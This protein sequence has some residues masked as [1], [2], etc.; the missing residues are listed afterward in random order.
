MEELRA[1][2][3]SL[4]S[5]RSARPLSVARLAGLAGLLWGVSHQLVLQP[6]DAR[7]A[8][9][10]LMVSVAI[11]WVGWM[12][13]RGL[14]APGVV[15]WGFL[16]LLAAAGGALAGYAPFA[17][18]FVAIAS[19]GAGIAFDTVG[20]LAIGAI[21]VGMVVMSVLVLGTSS[22]GEIVAEAALCAVAG[23]M[24]GNSRRQ[25]TARTEQ[26]ELLLAERM[27]ADA[28]RDTAAA[29]AERNRLGREVHDVLAHSLGALS[30]QL[31]AADAVLEQGQDPEKARQLVR[32]ARQL[33]VRGLEE[34]RQ[35]VHALRDDPVELAEQLVSLADREGAS[36]TVTG[37]PHRMA[38]DAGL[39]LYRVAQ[40]ALTNARKHAP[41]AAVSISL[42]FGANTTVLAV[43]NGPS[44]GEAN[45]A[46]LR[47]SGGG[48]GLR[49]MQERIELVGG[50]VCA[51]PTDSGFAVR[52][53][54]PG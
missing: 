35:A 10:L 26:A 17:L 1:R 6:G 46:D 29:L 7:W 16:A 14:S 25:Y 52:A 15:V 8:V 40:E 50:E 48:F 34:T 41:G 2:L 4:V 43:I 30:V 37:Q 13:S 45:G 22:P 31:D 28:E 32:Q 44:P 9:V 54:V 24:V 53:A 18:S 27:R 38:P 51:E 49:G 20:A 21:G 11:G 47:H 42:D 3:Q 39:A 5:T 19:L 12:A 36:V 23:V 33:A